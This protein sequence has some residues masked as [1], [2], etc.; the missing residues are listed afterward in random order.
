MPL[1]FF[2]SFH[3]AIIIFAIIFITLYFAIIITYVD[4][5]ALFILYYYADIDA[6]AILLFFILFRFEIFSPAFARSLIAA[7]RTLMLSHDTI[8]RWR[9]A[10]RA[11]IR[12]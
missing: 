6:A 4:F 3:D 8:A 12:H 7:A 5:L 10:A 1:L 11:V 2:I 9:D